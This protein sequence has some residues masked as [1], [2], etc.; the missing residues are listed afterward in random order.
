[1]EVTV[2]QSSA[3]GTGSNKK[4]AKRAAA[5]A[6][7]QQLGYNQ[8]IG[9]QSDGKVSNVSVSVKAQTIPTEEKPRKVTFLEDQKN[10]SGNGHTQPQ[11]T[12]SIPGG[13]AGR[14]LVPGLLLMCDQSNPTFTT[15]KSDVNIQTTATIAKEFL[16]AGNSPTADALASKSGHNIKMIQSDQNTKSSTQV[17]PKQQLLYLSKLLGFQVQFSDFPKANHEEFLTLL[18][19]NTE[20]PQVCSHRPNLTDPPLY[21]MLIRPNFL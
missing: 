11:S 7:L 6:L 10:D 20:P 3:T 14:Q 17:R 19:L 16:K 12:P 4:L 21:F 18:S 8:P 2:G 9:S 1:M 15:T 5:E 13:T